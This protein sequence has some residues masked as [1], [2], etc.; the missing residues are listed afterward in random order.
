[1]RYIPE[2]KIKKI[3]LIRPEMMGDTILLTSIVSTIKNKYP[4]AQIYLLLHPD[5]EEVVKNNPEIAGVITTK[6]NL[7]FS[8]FFA[9]AHRI[10]TKHFDISIVFEDNPTPQFAYLCL[11]AGIPYRIGDKARLA[12]GWTYNYGAWVDSSD[13]SLHHI[14]LYLKL[15]QPLHIKDSKFPLKL[16]LDTNALDSIN[17]FLPTKSIDEYF[18]GIHIGTGGGNRALLP[19]TYAKISDF[20]QDSMK[21]K[22][23]LIGG[24]GE[25]GTLEQIKNTAKKEFI[26]AVNRLSIQQLY[27]LISKLDV[28]IGVD[29]GPMH[30][31]AAFKIPIVAI[32]TAK[33]VNPA[34][35][36]P[37]M[38]KFIKIQ[39][40]VSSCNLK[41]SHRE[42]DKDFCL[43][44]IDPKEIVDSAKSIL[45]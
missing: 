39:S 32:Y 26:D 13:K 25:T 34:R 15:L 14:K 30:A 19:E 43:L 18:I 5:M 45:I 40:P 38:A 7:S 10:K 9:L 29:S 36:L 6:K 4:D 8:K 16:V 12:Y 17:K 37:W 28:F 42:C 24:A 33:D 35:W 21:C 27:A 3:L 23:F 41:C 20:L 11:I 22:V 44:A 1:M 2:S 31:A